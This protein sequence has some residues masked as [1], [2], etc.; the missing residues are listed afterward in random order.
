GR[1]RMEFDPPLRHLIIANGARTDFIG[2]DGT[3]VNT[4]TQ[5]TPLA[6]IFGARPKLSGEVQVLEIATKD[7]AAF[8]AVTQRSR[9][10][11]GKVILHFIKTQPTWTLHGWGFID[12]EGR[13]TKTILSS[14]RY[15][16]LLNANLFEAPDEN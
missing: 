9:P 4:A 15:D 6:L 8:F 12:P 10:K 7:N 13:Y 1:M 16:V 14:Q 11:A 3:V 2:G 5:S